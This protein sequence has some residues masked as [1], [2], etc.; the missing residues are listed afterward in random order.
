[1]PLPRH[2]ANVPVTTDPTQSA[3]RAMPAPPALPSLSS[4]SQ[5]LSAVS[6]TLFPRWGREGTGQLSGGRASKAAQQPAWS[7]RP[8]VPSL[9]CMPTQWRARITRLTDEH[10][11]RD[12][13]LLLGSYAPGSAPRA[14]HP[15]QGFPQVTARLSFPTVGTAALWGRYS[16]AAQNFAGGPSRARS[17]Q[18]WLPALG[19]QQLIVA[20]PQAPA[21][22]LAPDL[23]DGHVAP[24]GPLLL[25]GI[26]FSW[27]RV[28]PPPQVC[29][30]DSTGTHCI[31]PGGRPE[32]GAHRGHPGGACE[33]ACEDRQACEGQCCGR[34]RP[35]AGDT[36]RGSL[37]QDILAYTVHVASRVDPKLDPRD[38]NKKQ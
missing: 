29:C 18:G 21:T 13:V 14:P 7:L 37:G 20:A 38:T 23:P 24:G 33:P 6:V 4:D 16:R 26:L 12:A 35:E 3:L 8:L 31:K 30:R 36:W 19:G 27:K 28:T 34:G 5:R 1:M 22:S 17:G 32:E 25:P 9:V 15:N 10:L 2:R 11:E